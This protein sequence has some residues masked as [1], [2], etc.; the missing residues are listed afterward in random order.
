M[1]TKISSCGYKSLVALASAHG[2]LP[3]SRNK[4]VVSSDFAERVE[5]GNGRMGND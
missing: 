4:Y 5:R 3:K 2:K 1:W